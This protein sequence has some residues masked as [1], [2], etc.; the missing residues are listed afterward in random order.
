MIFLTQ[1]F[2]FGQSIKLFKQYNGQ[3]DY[4]GFGNTLNTEENNNPISSCSILTKSSADL[5]LASNQKP[6]AALLYWAG[7]SIGDFDVNLNGTPV[8]AQ[9]TFSF[10]FN[11]NP[12]F[13]AYADVTDI[14]T[15]NGNGT[16][17]LSNFDIRSTLINYCSGGVN[18][19]G[20]AVYV[21]F[22]QLDLPKNQISLYDG[23]QGVANTNP[24]INFN[25]TGLSV[26]NNELAKIGFLA[27]EGDRSLAN[28]ETLRINGDI[29]SNLPLNP[30]NNAF[31]GTNSY[32]NSSVL[33]NMD[34]DFYTIE[35]SVTPG[36]NQINIS[37]TSSQDFVLVNNVITV[38]NSE[39]PDATIAIDGAT[40]LCET[41]EINLDYTVSN[42]NSTADLDANIPIAFF[43]D[44]VLIGQ[45]QTQNIIPIGALENG[46]VTLTV[47]IGTPINFILKAIVDDDG[48]GNGIVLE[49]NEDNNE[50]QV[51]ISLSFETIDLGEDIATCSKEFFTL[52]AD[53]ADPDATFQW[54]LDGNSIEG[55]TMETYTVDPPNSGNYEVRVQSGVCQF[56]G[57]INILYANQP[58]I[59]NPPIDLFLCNDGATP[60]EFNLS[61]NTPI[62][63]GTQNPAEFVVTYYRT[64]QLSQDG[65]DPILNPTTFPITGETQEIF[66]SIADISGHCF[67]Y[68][69]FRIFFTPISISDTTKFIVCDPDNDGNETIDLDDYRSD[70]LNGQ[71][72]TA[73]TVTFY[74]TQTGA[75]SDIGALPDDYTVA[76]P[77]QTIYV[78]VQNN[79]NPSC[80]LTTTFILDVLPTPEIISLG[81]FELCDDDVYD[82]FTEFNLRNTDLLDQIQQGNNYMISF[83][84]TQANADA[85]ESPLPD[86]FTNSSNSQTIYIRAEDTTSNCFSIAPLILR[87]IV[88]PE[89]IFDGIYR[90]CVDGNGQLIPSEEGTS[91][92]PILDTQ[93][94]PSLYTFIWSFNG[95]V[96]P[97]KTGQS[98]TAMQEGSYKVVYTQ[99][100]NGCSRSSSAEVTLSSRPRNFSAEIVNNIF[101][102][103]NNIQVTTSGDGIYVYQIDNGAFQ[104][105]NIFEDVL[106]GSH[107][108]T[109]KDINGCGSVTFPFVVIDF[110]QFVTPNQDGFHDTWNIVGIGTLDPTAKI[111]IFD[112]FGKLLKQLNPNSGGWNGTYNG[113]PMP[114]SDYWFRVEYIEDGEQK[115]F[116]GHF[117]LKR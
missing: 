36:D 63:L 59:E 88:L 51:S 77:M 26:L 9:R 103:L 67:A 41:Q 3:L 2:T 98:L 70:A 52:D 19:G 15:T 46:S 8:A 73:Y 29:I 90:I 39:V 61:Q 33:Y 32:T 34:F 42:L 97:D 117:S 74:E 65:T 95:T 20:W 24:N 23:F 17:T 47:P 115:L 11:G 44:N 64:F 6:I 7:S 31:N 91:S 104:E 72:P 75:N 50:D 114:S 18:F 10:N 49:I 69:S 108:I 58:V 71:G 85:G 94:D 113:K 12:Y 99:N 76:V 60:N 87:V 79:F 107:I 43:A 80:F 110:P 81:D 92:P 27:W 30:A 66:I 111:Y 96:L 84:E 22:E 83:Y 21:I 57:N 25:L 109:I 37:L 14:I 102:G 35:N 68:A 78:R 40:P 55:A 54:Y 48:T 16:Y 4:T 106:Y 89:V 116:K 45:S 112:R 13:S 28:N 5:N 82:G 86:I 105:S 93:L 62:V 56:T 101:E 53:A 1:F 100:L 38:I